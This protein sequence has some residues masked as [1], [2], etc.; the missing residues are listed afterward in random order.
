[1]RSK[2]RRGERKGIGKRSEGGGKRES[3]GK[4]VVEGREERESIG[5]GG[6]GGGGKDGDIHYL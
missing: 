3:I 1:M 5:K 2:R 6:G 4:G